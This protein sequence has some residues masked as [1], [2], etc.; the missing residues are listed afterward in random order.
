MDSEGRA[1]VSEDAPLDEVAI[2]LERHRIRRVPIVRDGKLA[3]IVSRA[4]L[5]HGLVA[6]RTTALQP[7]NDLAIRD[8][9]MAVLGEIG[10]PGH[11]PNVV[12]SGG[13]A[14]LWGATHSQS[15]LDAVRVAAV[16]TP[17]V[18]RIE[19]NLFVLPARLRG[20]LGSD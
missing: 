2:L 11:F 18:K 16:T 14:Y 13:T 17:G 15:E 19:N 1:T 7:E 9:I 4:N 5:L 3:G 12:V 6:Q 10:I 20:A 8:T